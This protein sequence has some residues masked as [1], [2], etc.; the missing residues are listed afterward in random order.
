M[1]DA[2]KTLKTEWVSLEINK[3]QMEAYVAAPAEGGPYP[4]VL[5]FM[6]IFGVNVHI[7]KVTE[8]IAEQGYVA[9]AINYYHRTT[10]NLE[11]GYSEETMAIGRKHK[12]ATE[13][14][15]ILRDV[16]EAIDYLKFRPDTAPAEGNQ[17][18]FGCVG[19]CFGGHVAFIAA[20]LPEIAVAAAFYPGGVGEY[21]PGGGQ[22]TIEYV[23][24]IKAEL[25]VLYADQD[26]LIPQEETKVVEAALK[27]STVKHEVVHYPDATHG[28]FCDARSSYDP[29][30][31]EDAWG[32][33]VALFGKV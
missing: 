31:A 16:E 12:D 17:Y 26:P 4:G 9:I 22:P 25:L 19:F 24:D 18:K 28:F 1:A 32:K 3:S 8:R 10:D 33:L 6:E 5:V 29:K 15:N 2:V 20:T 21:S 7:R 23:D 30:V 11:L 14:R 13:R 27:E